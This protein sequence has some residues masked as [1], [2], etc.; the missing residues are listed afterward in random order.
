MTIIWKTITK[1]SIT[2]TIEKSKTTTRCIYYYKQPG[3]S[4]NYWTKD[5]PS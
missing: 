1:F 2:V 4:L 5:N 3:K